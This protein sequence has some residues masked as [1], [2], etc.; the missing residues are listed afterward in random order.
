[1]ALDSQWAEAQVC[2]QLPGTGRGPEP[3]HELDHLA[4]RLARRV[5][6]EGV[7]PDRDVQVAADGPGI[8]ALGV[9]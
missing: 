7:L 1:M 4:P 9:G 2:G 8:G 5:G 3:V 6:P